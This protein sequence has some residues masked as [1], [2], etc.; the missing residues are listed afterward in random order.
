VIRDLAAARKASAAA[1]CQE[2]SKCST[3]C[4][5]S[6]VEGFSAA[7][8][9]GIRDAGDV[10]PGQWLA[11]QRCLTCG[12]C[13]VRCPQGVQF[14]DY[15]RELRYRITDGAKEPCPHGTVIQASALLGIAPDAPPPTPAWLDDDLQVAETGAIGLFVGCLPQFDVMFGDEFGVEMTEI[16]RSAVRALN[17][18]GIEP[19][20]VADEQCCGHDLL[21]GGDRDGFEA[22]ARAN[23]A[24]FRERGIETVLTTC[25]ECS[26]TWRLDYPEVAPEYRPKV[27][28]MAEFLAERMEEEGLE[29]A[30]ADASVTYQDPCRLGRHLGVF[31][32]PRR[33]LGAAA[34]ADVVEM[35]GS[36]VDAVCC[37]TSG[38]INCDAESRRL[39]AERLRTA[40]ATGADTLITAC[41]KCLIHFSCAAGEDRRRG[42]EPP[43]IEVQDL[44]VFA[45]RLLAGEPA[46]VGGRKKAEQR[47]AEA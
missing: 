14:I 39:Q 5:L 41:P 47:G 28:H 18:L 9:M 11:V 17:H 2:C 8:I 20:L 46:G 23:T 25:G 38:F 12:A 35:P 29:F 22:L 45:A 24:A 13:Q 10:L 3:M 32:E 21:W 31:D 34:G 30:A 36:G 37:G 19:V 44:T 40:E 27:Q 15:V 42:R 4:P 6:G 1:L 26:R 43:A 16:A 33:V 7:R